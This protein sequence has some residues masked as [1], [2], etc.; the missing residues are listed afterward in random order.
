M[1]RYTLALICT[2]L[3]LL[4][5]CSPKLESPEEAFLDSTLIL[6][7]GIADAGD[8]TVRDYVQLLASLPKPDGTPAQ[9]IGWQHSD[10]G[11]TLRIKAAAEITL[12]FAWSKTQKVALLEYAETDGER[13]PAMQFF[14]LTVSMK[15]VNGHIAAPATQATA[16]EPM[17]VRRSHQHRRS[18][19]MQRPQLLRLTCHICAALRRPPS[20]PARP[21]RS[22]LRF[23]A[24]A[25][26]Q[27]SSWCTASRRWRARQRWSIQVTVLLRLPPSN[28]ARRL[29]QT[30]SR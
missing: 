12:P 25:A 6:R 10:G 20:S 29:H 4:S 23:V 16:A 2:V 28:T 18:Q 15:P 13:V 24:A 21:A 1:T 22:A 19:R 8:M 17:I 14:M 11:Y 7:P 27:P 26:G 3:M 5:A 30:A 9:I